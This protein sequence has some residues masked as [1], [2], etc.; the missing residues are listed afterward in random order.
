MTDKQA[1]INRK[2]LLWLIAGVI[3][4]VAAFTINAGFLPHSQDPILRGVETLDE[5]RD[6]VRKKYVEDVNDQKLYYDALRGMVSK[7]DPYSTFVSPEELDDFKRMLEGDFGG[8]GIYVTMKDGMLTV[9]TPIEGTPAFK[10]GL[11]AGD[12][13]LKVD[14][15]SIEGYNLVEA[16]KKL[17]GP[18]GTQVQL[19][20]LHISDTQPVEIEITRAKIKVH[21]VRGPRM[22]DKEAGIGYIRVTQFH[23][24]TPDEFR[25]AVNDLKEQGMKK[26]VLDLRFNPGGVMAGAVKVADEFLEKGKIVSTIERDG[27][28]EVA[29]ASEDGLLL[30]EPVAVLINQGSASAS[31]ILSAALQDHRRAIIIGTRSFGKGM[32]QSVFEVEGGKSRLKLTTAYYYTPAGHCV[33]TGVPCRHKNKYCF[34]K[35]NDSELELGG[36]N[37]NVQVE[38]SQSEEIQ[39]RRLM[40]DREIEYQK[41]DV[42][43]TALYDDMIMR[44]DRQLHQAVQYLKNSKLYDQAIARTSNATIPQ[45]K[46]LR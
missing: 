43:K 14:G 10:S 44:V 25:T 28:E 17:K 13:I 26:L 11:L 4:A 6:I 46:P 42:E 30:T 22:L 9:I 8:L 21:S 39:L 24:G 35:S 36:L 7:L 33:H 40:H 29:H 3:G 12:K 34:H 41:H 5:I 23:N 2:S 37:P 32:V 20:I 27:D 16:T 18:A 1:S 38:M 19:E 31:E 15:E 45:E